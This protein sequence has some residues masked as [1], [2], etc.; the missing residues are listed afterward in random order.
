MNKNTMMSKLLMEDIM[1]D[2]TTMTM[3]PGHLYPSIKELTMTIELMQK[4]TL[5]SWLVGFMLRNRIPILKLRRTM[6]IYRSLI[7]PIYITN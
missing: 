1:E 3:R 5:M 6:R 7:W 2:I 4:N